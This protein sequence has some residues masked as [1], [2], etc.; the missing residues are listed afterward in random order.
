MSFSDSPC[1][2]PYPYLCLARSWGEAD[3]LP[4][5]AGEGPNFLSSAHELGCAAPQTIAPHKVLHRNPPPI[6]E[7]EI[8][9][10]RVRAGSQDDS[11]AS[12]N[13][14]TLPLI[15]ADGVVDYRSRGQ[16]RTLYFVR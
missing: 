14:V 1:P 15:S 3:A 7:E 8:G 13:E 5:V 6:W 2:N 10:M 9:A 16:N 12:R 4:S 11:G